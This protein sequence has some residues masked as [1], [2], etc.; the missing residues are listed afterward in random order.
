M[1]KSIRTLM[2]A[3]ALA[4]PV[5]SAGQD[6]SGENIRSLDGQ[7]QTIKSDVLNIAAELNTLEER[8]LFPTHTQVSL[9]VAIAE[10]E[11]FRLDAV[12]IEIDG[13]LAT[14]HIYS[15]KEL[16]ALQEGGVQRVH[17]SNLTTGNHSMN[18][19]VIG[20]LR[21]GDAFSESGQF[22]ISK[23]VKPKAVGITLARPG[24]GR[25]PIQVGDW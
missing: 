3:A 12:K 1:S 17:T 5:V 7:V 25:D 16:E 2:V 22:T 14:H 21:N 20:Q 8:L 19:T 6:I 4:L 18:V 15:F 23:G 9:F 11:E 24:F 10:D 13:E